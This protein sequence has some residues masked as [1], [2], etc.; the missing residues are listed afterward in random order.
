MNWYE[1]LPSIISIYLVLISNLSSEYLRTLVNHTIVSDPSLDDSRELITNIAL[2]WADRLGFINFI[3]V[4]FI[5]VFSIYANTKSY[6]LAVGTFIVLW[7]IF[8]PVLL[9]I[10]SHPAGDLHGTRL[11]RY[12]IKPAD[13]CSIILVLMNI[14]L[15]IAIF[16]SQRSKTSSP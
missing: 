13:M 8:I 11:R 3:G 6:P 5:S 16:I 15:I 4:T 10:I 14:I 12:N 7:V 1:Y 9:W 2:D